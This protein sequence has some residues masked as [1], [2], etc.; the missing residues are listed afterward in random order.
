MD[1]QPNATV[2]TVYGVGAHRWLRHLHV[3]L[4]GIHGA[5]ERRGALAQEI[6]A[7]G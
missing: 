4:E 6:R 2:T 1:W 3:F 7:L 5:G